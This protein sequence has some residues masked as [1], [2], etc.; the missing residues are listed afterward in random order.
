MRRGPNVRQRTSVLTRNNRWQ[1]CQRFFVPL[2][3]EIPFVLQGA[4]VAGRG[5]SLAWRPPDDEEATTR[6]LHRAGDFD[7]PLENA[8]LADVS[9]DDMRMNLRRIG[10][11]EDPVDII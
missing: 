9:P 4:T 10:L 3:Q 5:E 1:I 11:E 6:A 8:C 7:E 2:E